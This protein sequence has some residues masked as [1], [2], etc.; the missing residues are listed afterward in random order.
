[1]QTSYTIYFGEKPY[2]IVSELHADLKKLSATSG[3]V[4]ANQF[5]ENLIRKTIS[6]I[7][8]TDAKAVIVLT[9]Q[10]EKA[11]TFFQQSFKPVTAG[12]GI[13]FNEK[14]EVLFI[15]R[16]GK[17]DLPKG[18]LDKGE[19][20]DACALREVR[21]ETGLT[22]LSLG[23]FAGNTYHVYHEK[24][25]HILKTTVWYKMLA[26]GNQVFIPQTEE[27]I[28]SMEWI[29]KKEWGKPFANTFPAIKN[30]LEELI[31]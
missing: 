27:D 16:R 1:M 30:I 24:K 5:D 6:D 25:K 7:E 4:M 8:N 23:E 26:A 9:N 18:K 29:P 12:G 20:I 14:N 21:E 28:E 17:W 11:W 19:T 22:T 2:F 31:F 10:V 13:V 15:Y 3:T